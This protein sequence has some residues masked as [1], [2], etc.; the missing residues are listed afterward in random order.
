MRR[1]LAYLIVLVTGLS[2]LLAGCGD[3]ATDEPLPDA[4]TLLE[5]ATQQI[6]MAESFALEIMLTGSPVTIGVGNFPLPMDLPLVFDYARGVFVA[7]D[8]ISADV[9]VSLGDLAVSVNLIAIGEEQYMRSDT[10]TQGVWLQEEI[11]PGF[12]PSSLVAE[13]GGISSSLESIAN[14]EMVGRTDLDGL[15]VYHL[16]GQI[17]ARNVY[18]LTFGLIGT[19]EGLLDVDVYILT[20]ERI[21]EQV[22][23]HEPAPALPPASAMQGG[24]PEADDED[25]EPTVWTIALQGYNE[26]YTIEAPQSVVATEAAIPAGDGSAPADDEGVGVT[27]EPGDA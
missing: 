4:R 17:E 15:N 26:A 5:E 18:S 8:R 3:S 24:T 10:L 9:Q 6:Q 1:P 20:D 16:T 11:I 25:L 23:L 27:S 2:I 21:V 19:T 12:R 7:P 14:L 13:E 22:V